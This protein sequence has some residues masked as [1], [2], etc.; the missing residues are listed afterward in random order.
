[1]YQIVENTPM[2]LKRI[3]SFDAAVRAVACDGCNENIEQD[4][5]VYRVPVKDSAKLLTIGHKWVC[6]RCAGTQSEAV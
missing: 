6:R 4:G 1:M 3:G 2:G 5:A